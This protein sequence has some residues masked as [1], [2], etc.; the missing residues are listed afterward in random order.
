MLLFADHATSFCVAAAPFLL[1]SRFRGNDRSR[2]LERWG[3]G[4]LMYIIP[5]IL[6]E[7]I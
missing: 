1:D 7:D 4:A 6:N 3:V 5:L 2:A